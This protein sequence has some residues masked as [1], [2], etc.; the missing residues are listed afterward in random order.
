MRFL[1]V[2]AAC[3][4]LTLAHSVSAAA[5]A[6]NTPV[7]V[8]SPAGKSGFQGARSLGTGKSDGDLRQRDPALR[9]RR[10]RNEWRR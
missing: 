1:H 6:A 7:P 3:A 8:K 2:A 10:H 9:S 4:A 5:L